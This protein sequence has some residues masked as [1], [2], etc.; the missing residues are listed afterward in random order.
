MGV[1]DLGGYTG[2]ILRV[3]LGRRHFSEESFQE[4]TLRDYIGGVGIGIKVLYDEVPPGVSWS[5]G[6]NSLILTTGP[7]NGTSVAGSGTICAVTKGCLT[8][9]G[10]SSQ[11]NGYF[12]AYLKTSGVDGIVIQGTSEHWTYLTSMMVSWNLEMRKV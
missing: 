10:A 8:N 11:A 2:R 4:E 9:G 12:G 3:D 6:K 5:D 7:L 1:K